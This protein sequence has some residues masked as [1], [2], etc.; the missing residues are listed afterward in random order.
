MSIKKF[1]FLL[2]LISFPNLLLKSQLVHPKYLKGETYAVIV[3]ITDYQEDRLDLSVASNDAFM[4]ADYLKKHGFPVLDNDHMQVLTDQRAT[5]NNI[6]AALSWATRVAGKDDRIVFF[7]SGHGAPEGLAAT[8]FNTL[9]GANLVYHSSIKSLLKKSKSS[10]M[11]MIVDACHSGASESAFYMGAVKDIV[12]GYRNSGITMLLSSS[13]SQSSLE[14]GSV[15]LS[16]FTH[17]LLEGINQGFANKNGD[18]MITIQEAFDYVK[19]NVDVLT[20]G[21]QTPQKAGDF[22]RSIVMRLIK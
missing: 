11:L 19:L 1:I 16:Y 12:K 17:Y 9:T 2:L 7:F 18:N 14:Y 3:G 6:L 10:Q 21:T 4:M 13:A 15:G 5:K 22:D 20:E 8:D